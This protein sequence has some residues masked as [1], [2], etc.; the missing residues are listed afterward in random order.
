MAWDY[1]VCTPDLEEAPALPMKK[2]QHNLP[3]ATQIESNEPFLDLLTMMKT[4][5]LYDKK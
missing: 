3:R 5:D 1:F 4:L 2:A